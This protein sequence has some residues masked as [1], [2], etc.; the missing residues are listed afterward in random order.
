MASTAPRRLIEL[1]RQEAIRRAQAGAAV[2][3]ARRLARA[4]RR[5]PAH[6]HRLAAR[7]GAS[8]SR[9]PAA[10]RGTCCV[11]P[12]IWTG[13]SPHHVRFG[14]TVIAERV[15]VL[16]AGARG[17]RRPRGL[18]SDRARRERPRGEP[19]SADHPGRRDRHALRQLLRAV[20][21][22]NRVG[23]SRSTAAPRVTQASSRR[24]ISLVVHERLV[25][26]PDGAAFE[27]IAVDEHALLVPDMGE[28]GVLGDPSAAT[29]AA[30][31]EFLEAVTAAL[32][33]IVEGLEPR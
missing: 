10:R 20:Q 1:P 19:R 6:R 5:A 32:A 21:T 30:G 13:F 12:T 28:S 15:R 3:A 9:P 11:A 29:T 22:P 4:A 16:D 7:R 14:A 17:L 24:R 2:L 31:E 27:P 18:G 25:G 23:S 26:D 33:R 8:A